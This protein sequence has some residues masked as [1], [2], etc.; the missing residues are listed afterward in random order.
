MCKGDSVLFEMIL[1]A[2]LQTGEYDEDC[3]LNLDFYDSQG[4]TPLLYACTY[5]QVKVVKILVAFYRTNAS[6]VTLNVN[7]VHKRSGCT[8]L[9]I[10]T[11]LGDMAMVE[12]LLSMENI[13]I[14]AVAKP[15]TD[16]HDHIMA[17][18]PTPSLDT[19]KFK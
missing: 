13:D 10:A 1:N 9:H 17:V 16:L 4:S 12:I 6:C 7:S 18:S 5:G 14:D 3:K 19:A 8:P 15:S 11:Q 2:L